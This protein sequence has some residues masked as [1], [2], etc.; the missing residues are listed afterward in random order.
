VRPGSEASIIVGPLAEAVAV[1]LVGAGGEG[2]VGGGADAVES[3]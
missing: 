1:A 3:A 2:G